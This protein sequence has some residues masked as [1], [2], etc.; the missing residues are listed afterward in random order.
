MVDRQSQPRSCSEGQAGVL[1]GAGVVVV[2]RAV[3]LGSPDHVRQRLGHG[4]EP[5][6]ALA[7]RLLGPLALGD[8]PGQ[9][10][11]EAAAALPERL[12]P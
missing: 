6:L 10:H 4:A 3:R 1:G 11:R 2:G 8:V 7:Q 9:G 5:P 12:G